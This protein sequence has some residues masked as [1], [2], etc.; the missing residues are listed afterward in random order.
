MVDRSRR[1]AGWARITFARFDG[2]HRIENLLEMLPA[3][4]VA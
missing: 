3:T 2:K 4:R 1:R